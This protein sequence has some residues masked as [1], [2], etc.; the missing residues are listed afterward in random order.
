[1]QKCTTSLLDAFCRRCCSWLAHLGHHRAWPTRR[2]PVSVWLLI[3]RLHGR[4]PKSPL[5][6]P[7][8]LG[9]HR[10][11]WPTRRPWPS[12]SMPLGL[13]SEHVARLPW[14]SALLCLVLI[15]VKLRKWTTTSSPWPQSR[16]SPVAIRDLNV[17]VKLPSRQKEKFCSNVVQ[18][19]Y[20]LEMA[21]VLGWCIH[22]SH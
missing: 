6:L 17:E 9:H 14:T 2:P 21:T 12:T 3:V 5:G 1:M 10:R 18:M 11:W 4:P 19:Q 16:S 22:F 15:L 8:P 7:T 20:L 13:P